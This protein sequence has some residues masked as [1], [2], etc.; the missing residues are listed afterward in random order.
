MNKDEIVI[1]DVVTCPRCG[2][3]HDQVTFLEFVKYV[4][5]NGHWHY[6]ATCPQTQEPILMTQIEQPRF[7][8]MA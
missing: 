3:D 6:W 8:R 1:A 7:N 5:A 2:Q 4:R